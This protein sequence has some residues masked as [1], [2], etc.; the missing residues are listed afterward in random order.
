VTATSTAN[1]CVSAPGTTEVVVNQTP[2]GSFGPATAFFNNDETFIPTMPGWA[3]YSWE[4]AGGIPATSTALNPSVTWSE[5]GTYDVTLTMTSSGCDYVVTNQVVVSPDYGYSGDVQTFT[6]PDGVTSLNLECWGAEGGRS[7]S[8]GPGTAAA[9]KGGYASG[10][11]AVTPGATVYM[12][13]GGQGSPVVGDGYGGGGYNGG[14][15][16]HAG[17]SSGGGGATDI[18]IGGTMLA[19]RVLVA[20]GGGGIADPA[21]QALWPGA[22]AVEIWGAMVQTAIWP[23]S[24]GAADRAE[25]KVPEVSAVHPVA[26]NPVH[27]AMADVVE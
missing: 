26:E 23:V 19:H 3:S 4:F 14:A 22:M 13:V 7:S 9:G 15:D 10:T 21:A 5:P 11:L 8:C 18:R 17:Y 24:E 2:W 27:L 6:V 12:Y 1:G 16:G 20:G 25:R